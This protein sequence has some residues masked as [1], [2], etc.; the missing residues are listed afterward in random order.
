MVGVGSWVAHKIAG[1]EE[2]FVVRVVG[3]EE[4]ERVGKARRYSGVDSK[5]RSL[6]V[7][8]GFGQA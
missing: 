3:P 8:E 2:W 6:G 7:A 1:V 4:L 5:G